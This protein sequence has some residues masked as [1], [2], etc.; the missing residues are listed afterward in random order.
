MPLYTWKNK[1]TGEVVEIFR[2]IN[3]YQLPP[4]LDGE[5]VKLI[6]APA[7]L[8][9][10]EGGNNRF[11]KQKEYNTIMKASAQAKAK[12]DLKESKRI[13]SEVKKI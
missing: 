2:G 3:D 9:S 12:G 4:E 5:W 6:D 7:G 10:P 11:Q 8:M 13:K 1:G